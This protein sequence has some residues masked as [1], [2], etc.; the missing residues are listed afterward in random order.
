MKSAD[1]ATDL[2]L[3]IDDQSGYQQLTTRLDKGDMVLCYSDAFTD[4]R[5]TDGKSLGVDGMLRTVASI[6][7]T[8]EQALISS[9][10]GAIR[11]L[12]PENLTQDDATIVLLSR[13]WNANLDP[14]QPVSAVSLLR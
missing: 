2:P 5:G 3:G 1:N 6:P 11:A 7:H 8:D 9:L 14:R 10:F 12:H 13:Q 4:A